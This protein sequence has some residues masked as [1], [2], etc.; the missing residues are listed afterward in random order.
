[1]TAVPGGMSADEVARLLDLAPLPDEGGRFRRT[2]ADAHSS[3]ILYLLSAGDF[4]AL[5]RLTGPEVYH[6]H[7]GDPAVLTLLDPATGQVENRLL[8]TDLAA[9]QLPQTVVPAGCWQGSRT[10]G[11]WTLLGT[12]M[13][14]GFT[15]EMFELGDRAALTA[16]FPDAAAAIAALTR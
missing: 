15:A 1:M 12:T 13:A 16:A 14:P 2:F 6:L 9:G 3:A 10:T 5:H 4:S 8:G 11:A 7:A